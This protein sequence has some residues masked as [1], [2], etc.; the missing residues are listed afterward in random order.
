MREV[1]L[2]R[3][4]GLSEDRIKR[5]LDDIARWG[6]TISI[7]T[8]S[9]LSGV[10]VEVVVESESETIASSLIKGAENNIKKRLGEN[11]YGIGEEESL[12]KVIGYLFYLNRMTLAVAESVTGGLVSHIITNIPGAS[13]YFK[14][15][16]IAYSNDVKIDLLSVASRTIELFGAVSKKTAEEMAIGVRKKL[17]ADVG[18]S[19]TGIAGPTGSTPIKPIGLVYIGVSSDKETI[20]KEFLFAGERE[21]I[22]IQAAYYGLD[23]VRRVMIR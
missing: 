20:A 16:I 2:F 4:I 8:K 5:M 7:T 12:E 11:I 3:T 22:K 14:G 10:D 17:S 19:T 13:D 21:E 18:L 9:A 6:K 15:S 1:R 23:M